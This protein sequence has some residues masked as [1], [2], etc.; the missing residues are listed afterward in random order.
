MCDVAEI[1]GIT[2]QNYGATLLK[3]PIYLFDPRQESGKMAQW[4]M[5]R[6][7]PKKYGKLG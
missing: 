2:V 3:G 7:S 4:A 1:I 5:S 6:A